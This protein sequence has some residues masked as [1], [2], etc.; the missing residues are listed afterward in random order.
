[1][2]GF[3]GDQAARKIIERAGFGP[4]F[5]H[6]TGHSIDR[7]LHGSGPHLDDFETHDE[8][9]LVPGVIAYF[10]LRRT[11]ETWKQEQTA[12]ALA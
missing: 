1:M 12:S 4:W 8:R 3:E 7:D 5:V 10:R 6:R 9:A 11:I 2:R